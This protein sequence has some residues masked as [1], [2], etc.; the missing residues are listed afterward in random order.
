MYLKLQ[1]KIYIGICEV[2]IL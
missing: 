2:K 1:V